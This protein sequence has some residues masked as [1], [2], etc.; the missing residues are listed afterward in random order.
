M[1]LVV[2]HLD[3]GVPADRIAIVSRV[4]QPYAVLVHEELQAA[5]IAHSVRPAPFARPEHR[6]AHVA[7]I[8]ALAG[9][10]ASTRRLMRLLRSAPIR[11]PAVGS[12]RPDRWDRVARNA[13]VVAGLDQW[14]RRLD[15]AKRSRLERVQATLTDT[16]E[17]MLPL[18]ADT[19]E[20]DGRAAEIDALRSFVDRL[21]AATDPGEKRG[22]V[23]SAGGPRRC[24][25]VIW[26]TRARPRRGPR[27]T[28]AL[29]P[30]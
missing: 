23:G 17:P 14:H 27:P 3:A 1:R 19:V 22:G 25:C 26:A 21:A 29:A 11:D 12:T 8:A 9:E 28:S 18:D 13:G 15:E 4:S 5:G 7:R 2:E 30:R 6:G 16:T 24:S 20:A 10:R